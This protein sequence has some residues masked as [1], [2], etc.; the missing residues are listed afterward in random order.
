MK[1]LGRYELVRTLGRGGAGE[2]FEAVL[3]GPMG[4]Q[5]SVALKVLRHGVDGFVQEFMFEAR[6]GA[7][8]AHPNVVGTHELGQVDGRWFIAMELVRGGSARQLLSE[9][10]PLPPR[11]VIEIGVQAASGL[12]HI[13]QLV[14]DGGSAGLVHRDIKPANLLVSKDGLVKIAD[15]GIA[16]LAGSERG[17]GGTYGYVPAEQLEERE[18]NRADLFALGVTLHRLLTGEPLFGK[19]PK[20]VMAVMDADA[21]LERNL[22]LASA[23]LAYGPLAAVIRACVRHQPDDR[24]RSAAVLRD[25]LLRLLPD[26]PGVGLT[27]WLRQVN[28]PVAP[29]PEVPRLPGG[30]PTTWAQHPC[31]GRDALTRQV[32]RQLRAHRT[33]VLLG[34]EGM[35][36]TRLAV[37]VLRRRTGNAAFVDL[38]EAQGDQLWS[39][40]ARA[41]EVNVGAS[42]PR[43]ALERWLATAD[44][45]L[46][47]LDHV[48]AARGVLAAAVTSWL[49]LAPALEVL[50]TSRAPVEVRGAVRVAVGPLEV[51]DGVAL[52]M[53][54]C[55]RKASPKVLRQVVEAVGGVPLGIE[56]AASRAN[57]VGVDDALEELLA[58]AEVAGPQRALEASW[59]ALPPWGPSALAQLAVF[60]DGF[61]LDAADAVLDL[62][63]Y[64]NAPWV[65]DALTELVGRSLLRVDA[66][67]QRFF[68]PP[69]V[70]AHAHARSPFEVQPAEQRHGA[71]FAQ[72]GT[73]ASLMTL[74]QRRG[75]TVRRR[76]EVDLDNVVAA[77]RRAVRRG[78]GDIASACALAARRVFEEQGPV[79]A[80]E[81]L[82]AAVQPL[83]G[84]R[85]VEV[86][87]VRAWL[88][89]LMGRL[90]GAAGL[91]AA[92]REAARRRGDVREDGLSEMYL[93]LVSLMQGDHEDAM[94]ALRIAVKRFEACGDQWLQG[95][96]L[97]NLAVAYND[98]PEQAVEV[99]EANAQLAR[100]I[101]DD[102]L[103][104]LSLANRGHILSWLGRAQ[105]ARGLLT[106]ALDS[107]VAR[108]S[109]RMEGV[110]RMY[111]GDLCL[112]LGGLGEA[113]KHLVLSVERL[114]EVGEARMLGIALCVRGHLE[115]QE[116]KVE[117]ALASCD[118]GLVAVAGIDA[119]SHYGVHRAQALWLLGR[120]REALDQLTTCLGFLE[121]SADPRYYAF[122]LALRAEWQARPADLSLA[123]ARLEGLGTQRFITTQLERSRASLHGRR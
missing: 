105:E 47:V 123:E 91:A 95:V 57:E 9:H 36:K 38:S 83:A 33:V 30:V 56:L 54:L 34:D 41:V 104:E 16:R 25:R 112:D 84:D 49:S 26:A 74:T 42:D 15:L 65:L 58:P 60:V 44:P 72:F 12:E 79:S 37:E 90:D 11:A 80:A 119:A 115:L 48:D 27:A 2:V 3:H 35:G 40:I 46:L 77:A 62:A 87:N 101:D 63:G 106:E 99:Y 98:H 93:G 100:A 68:V 116:G 53:G 4:F 103:Y 111:L 13:H 107:A 19:G 110:V 118:E 24:I 14:L 71:W 1:R 39:A 20:A 97:Q 73:P 21:Y 32:E 76:L 51:E 45:V 70:R 81:V 121:T 59:R 10:G 78:D 55:Q 102:R 108:R 6:L 7:M 85:T 94:R 114:R 109:R 122:A 88:H 96:A 8:L 18:D 64:P 89:I 31:I 66:E 43:Q 50:L 120:R 67:A 5:K 22:A 75:R 92:A 82:L 69:S 61:Y 86:Q 28:D 23:R 29:E 17:V 52:F 113:R 117:D